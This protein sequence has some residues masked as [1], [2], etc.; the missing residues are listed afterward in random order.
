[1]TFLFHEEFFKLKQDFEK[2]AK[3]N[4]LLQSKNPFS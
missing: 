4:Q 1:M 2:N 3:E